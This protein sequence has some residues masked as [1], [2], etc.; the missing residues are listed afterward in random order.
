MVGAKPWSRLAVIVRLVIMLLVSS[1]SSASSGIIS[2]IDSRGVSPSI[3]IWVLGGLLTKLFE[4]SFE[5]SDVLAV[6]EEYFDL[7]AIAVFKPA[8][9]PFLPLH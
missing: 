1:S 7:R 4:S 9:V 6:G 3:L 8:L 5:V 2:R